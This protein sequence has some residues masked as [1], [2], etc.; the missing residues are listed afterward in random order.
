MTQRFVESLNYLPGAGEQEEDEKK[1]GDG[2]V[3]MK[4]APTKDNDDRNINDRKRTPGMATS[5]LVKVVQ[6]VMALMSNSNGS[7]MPYSILRLALLG[8]DFVRDDADALTAIGSCCVLVRGN[9]C[10]H[11]Q[12]AG[13][14]PKFVKLRTFVLWKLQTEGYVERERLVQIQRCEADDDDEQQQ[15]QDDPTDDLVSS[16][17]LDVMLG[18][19]AKRSK[20]KSCWLLKLGDNHQFCLAFPE[21]VAL[22]KQYWDRQANKLKDYNE[23]YMANETDEEEEDGDEIA[24]DEEVVVAKEEVV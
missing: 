17:W 12:F 13:L 15:Q 8:G 22:H 2:D 6:K 1:D 23:W 20:A 5:L 7:P 9:F 19:V 10:L 21:H 16:G 14:P 11:S 24:G 4:D 18:Q 3:N